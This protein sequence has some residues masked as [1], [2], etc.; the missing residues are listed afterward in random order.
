[1]FKIFHKNRHNKEKKKNEQDKEIDF[2]KNEFK[3]LLKSN[4][5]AQPVLS[6]REYG[7]KKQNSNKRKRFEQQNKKNRSKQ[8]YV[9]KYS[10]HK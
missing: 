3:K 1:M 4:L 7:S 9:S 5:A 2:Q 8:Y 10:K 6:M